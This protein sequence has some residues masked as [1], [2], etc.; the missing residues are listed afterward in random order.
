[1]IKISNLNNS[2]PYRLLKNYYDKAFEAGEDVIEAI[3]IASFDNKKKE[4]DARFVNL[5]YIIDEE[6]IFFTNYNSPKSKQFNSHNQISAILYWKS[7]NMQIRIKAEI[8]KTSNNFSDKHFAN[9]SIHK[10]ALSISSRQSNVIE[11]YEHIIANYKDQLANTG[12][13]VKRPDYWG[14]Y[15]FTPFY[16][17]FWEGHE[18]RI[19][20][21]EVFDKID[22]IW[23]HSFIQP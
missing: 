7:I 22:G 13:T 12:S 4:V 16:F 18:S 11:S 15:S 8:Y 2:E 23:K 19:N 14:G 20:K 9:R 10:N 3:L 5:K 17:E 1:M 6:W 21:R